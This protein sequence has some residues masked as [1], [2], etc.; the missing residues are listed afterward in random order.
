MRL[1]NLL[2]L[3]TVL[4]SCGNQ[5]TEMDRFR[6]VASVEMREMN[7][8]IDE[9]LSPSISNNSDQAS[10]KVIKSGEISFESESVAQDYQ[11]VKSLIANYDSYIDYENETNTDYQSTYDITIRV[12]ADNYDSLYSKLATVSQKVDF[13]SSNT[14]DV[15]ERYYDLKTRIKNK[16]ALEEKYLSLLKKATTI[17]DILE[18]ERSLNEIR[19][20]IETAEGSFRYLSKQVSYST[21]QLSFYETLPSGYQSQSFW[22]RITTAVSRGWTGFLSFLVGAAQAWPFILISVLVFLGFKKI[23]KNKFLKK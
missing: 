23:R 18:I 21:I 16:K 3:S 5:E 2:L 17:K 7:A 1:L 14:E 11:K 20:E 6:E 22:S 4:F 8:A 19:N 9:D 12:N 13:K 10:K 15:T